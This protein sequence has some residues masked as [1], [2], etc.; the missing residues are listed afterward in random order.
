MPRSLSEQLKANE[1]SPNDIIK[2][3]TQDSRNFMLILLYK[4]HLKQKSA[5]DQEQIFLALVEHFIN[6]HQSTIN[7][8][9][10]ITPAA[11]LEH[12]KLLKN[13]ERKLVS[14]PCFKEGQSFT[15]L[16]TFHDQVKQ[17][18]QIYLSALNSDIQRMQET[19]RRANSFPSV[20][21][22]IFVALLVLITVALVASLI[23]GVPAAVLTMAGIIFEV[24]GGITLLSLLSDICLR[25]SFRH[26][27][28]TL[29]DNCEKFALKANSNTSKLSIEPWLMSLVEESTSSYQPFPVTSSLASIVA[30]TTSTETI[31]IN[32]NT[33]GED[34]LPLDN[35]ENNVSA[36]Q[37]G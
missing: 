23:V 12:L 36:H 28:R 8:I 21:T 2:L 20:R 37:P 14:I 22:S 7:S 16:K 13:I 18:Q 15:K 1:L 32:N 17:S 11:R 9:P 34:P 31:S 19:Q 29:L 24:A 27:D 26:E 30:D 10:P 3:A 33:A 5:A 25:P 6:Q 35:T 4:E